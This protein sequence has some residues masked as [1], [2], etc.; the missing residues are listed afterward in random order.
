M[1]APFYSVDYLPC[2]SLASADDRVT[3]CHKQGEEQVSLTINSLAPTGAPLQYLDSVNAGHVFATIVYQSS[4][5][6]S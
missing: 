2:H 6:V 1:K 4:K 3:R 5:V